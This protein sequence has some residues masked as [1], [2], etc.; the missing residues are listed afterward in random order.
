MTLN[1][2]RRQEPLDHSEWA[3]LLPAPVAPALP[4]DRQLLLE[5]QL[6]QEIQQHNTAAVPATSAPSRRA[7]RL[8]VRLAA[9]VAVAAAAVGAFLAFNPSTTAVAGHTPAATGTATSS[10]DM[11]ISTVAYT[12]KQESD[13]RVV[14]TVHSNAAVDAA[15]LQKDL[16]KV[17]IMATVT[18]GWPRS[19]A[20]IQV[21]N[22]SVGPKNG[23]YVVTVA[24]NERESIIFKLG[25]NYVAMSVFPST[26]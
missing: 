18:K 7:R 13:G 10:P 19:A 2:W 26:N 15:Q 8:A 17:G 12:L 3:R 23:D 16:G 22:K 4:H 14:V 11:R 6:M 20:H 25:N 24:R 1:L 21:V 5:E 9:P